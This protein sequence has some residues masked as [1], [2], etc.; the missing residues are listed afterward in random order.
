MTPD[1][2]AGDLYLPTGRQF[3]AEYLM[4]PPFSSKLKHVTKKRAGRDLAG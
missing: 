3:Q 1:Q 2:I 4:L